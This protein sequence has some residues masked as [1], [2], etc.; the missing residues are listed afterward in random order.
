MAHAHAMR[1]AW[2]ARAEADPLTAIEASRRRWSEADFAADGRRTTE[3]VMGWLGDRVE[4]G[5]MLEIGCGVCRTALPFA[6]V[7]ERV[8]AIDV[9]PRM[10]ALA[11]ARG[12]PPNVTLRASDGE[13]LTGFG[14]ASIDFVF[15]EHVFQ[16]VASARVIERYLS[17][18]GRVLRPRGAA[19][20][21]FDTRPRGLDRLMPDRV[22]ARL[23]PAR[24]R[25]HIRRYRRD[26]GWVRTA[27]RAAGLSIEWER[28]TGSHW[29][30]LMLAPGVSSS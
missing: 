17:E 15:S 30:W 9:A 25:P 19:L 3:L 16:H 28:G 4:R 27:A 2:N 14:D 20:F 29:H 10:V 5:R 22:P 1:A 21:Q 26:P 23:L 18:T 7:F 11:H 13:T 6:D 12:L 24:H 8:E